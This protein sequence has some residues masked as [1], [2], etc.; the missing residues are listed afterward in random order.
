M[1][2]VYGCLKIV[3]TGN[4]LVILIFAPEVYSYV[5]FRFHLDP[6]AFLL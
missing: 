6:A 5:V 1:C 2:L 3:V 4:L